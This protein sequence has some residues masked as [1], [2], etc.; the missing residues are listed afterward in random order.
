MKNIYLIIITSVLFAACKTAKLDGPER[1]I[2][3]GNGGGIVGK[4]H[5]YK[6]SSLG[7][8]KVANSNDSDREIKIKVSRKTLKK[9]FALADSL[10]KNVAGFS[11]PGNIYYFISVNNN[12][13]KPDYTWGQT[14]FIAPE[15]VTRLYD[16]LKKIK[17]SGKI[18][19]E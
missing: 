19:K 6:I 3:F 2:I 1:F 7:A 16:M 18:L 10:Q 15:P 12:V 14:G 5:T 4:E 17:D 8:F 11:N 13:E 9:I